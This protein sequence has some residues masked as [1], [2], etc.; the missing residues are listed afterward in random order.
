MGKTVESHK[1]YTVILLG[2]QSFE[3]SPSPSNRTCEPY[4]SVFHRAQHEPTLQGGC[5]VT[6]CERE[7]SNHLTILSVTA[8]VWCDWTTRMTAPSPTRI[9]GRIRRRFS[10]HELKRVPILLACRQFAAPTFPPD[11]TN[12]RYDATFIRAATMASQTML[13]SVIGSRIRANL[14]NGTSE[15]GGHRFNNSKS[16]TTQMASR[17]SS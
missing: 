16:Q 1:Q 15:S 4:C 10:H 8:D 6:P 2:L 13:C 11:S 12:P 17:W 9:R 7:S 5:T 3:M 14:M